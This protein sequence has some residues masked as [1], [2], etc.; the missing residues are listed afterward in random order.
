ML[1]EMPAA[2]RWI[3]VEPLL[4][5]IDLNKYHKELD[6]NWLTGLDK[7]YPEEGICM[8]I[9]WVVVGAESMGEKAGRECKNEWIE[10][11]VSQCREAGVPVFV[12]QTQRDGKIIKN[13]NQFPK[14][15]QIQEYPKTQSEQPTGF[16]KF[17]SGANHRATFSGR[18]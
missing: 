18:G 17:R 1:L 3:S 2:V 15:L 10:D 12:K 16:A 7:N 8:K 9:D 14:H 11:I 6:I 5:Q 13:I 4:A